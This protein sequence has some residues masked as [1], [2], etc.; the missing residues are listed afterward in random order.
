MFCIM[1]NNHKHHF[2]LNVTCIEIIILLKMWIFNKNTV[3]PKFLSNLRLF[4]FPF[5]TQMNLF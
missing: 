2:L 5:Q 1:M 4:F 3:I